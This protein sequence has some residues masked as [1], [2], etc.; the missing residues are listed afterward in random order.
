[1]L[2]KFLKEAVPV[3]EDSAKTTFWERLLGAGDRGVVNM[4]KTVAKLSDK[5][6]ESN[7]IE[8]AA[9]RAQGLENLLR[10][11]FAASNAVGFGSLAGGGI[12]F[13][14]PNDPTQV[15][16]HI[17]RVTEAYNKYLEDPL[18]T[19]GGLPTAVAN[20]VVDGATMAIPPIDLP[21]QGFRWAL[22]TW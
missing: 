15:N 5:F 22:S 9:S 1:V 18:T 4:M 12:E 2:A 14:G 11:D 7:A 19:D 8:A 13:D 17:P 20:D 6:S 16:W 10:I 21:L 3:I